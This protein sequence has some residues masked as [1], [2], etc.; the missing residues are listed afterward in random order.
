VL[1]TGGTRNLNIFGND[2]RISPQNANLFVF[3]DGNTDLKDN[4]FNVK[5]DNISL[6]AA[7]IT[8]NG[9]E[10]TNPLPYELFIYTGLT[11][12]TLIDTAPVDNYMREWS[13]TAIDSNREY[14][15]TSRIIAQTY[16][17]DTCTL[18]E[19][20]T[21]DIGLV[22]DKISPSITMDETNVYL[23]MNIQSGTTWDIYVKRWK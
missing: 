2:N 10:L 5:T 14:I 6:S 1:N 8:I 13:Y 12:E 7:S 22:A 3:G 9:I 20:G 16:S 17:A 18:A 23:T 19:Y 21:Q 4:S 11:T 15:R